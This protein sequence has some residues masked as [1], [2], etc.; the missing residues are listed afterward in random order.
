VVINPE[1]TDR[2]KRSNL[3]ALRNGSDENQARKPFDGREVKKGISL[4]QTASWQ[5]SVSEEVQGSISSRY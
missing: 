3:A 2:V 5:I 4:I 1:P